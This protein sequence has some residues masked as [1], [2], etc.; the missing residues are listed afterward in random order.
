MEDNRGSIEWLDFV[1]CFI[2]NKYWFGTCSLCWSSANLISEHEWLLLQI[3][4]SCI[5]RNLFTFLSLFDSSS[6]GNENFIENKALLDYSKLSEGAE[7]V[8]PSSMALSEFHFL[9]LLGNKVKVC[10]HF[11]IIVLFSPIRH[12]PN[13]KSFIHVC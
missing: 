1:V 11:C 10:M 6:G 9:L 13:L 12:N 4:R 5:F 2:F 8:K 3:L 7:V